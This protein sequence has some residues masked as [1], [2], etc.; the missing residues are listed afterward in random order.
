VCRLGCALIYLPLHVQDCISRLVGQIVA[1][2][3]PTAHLSSDTA[4]AS[5]SRWVLRYPRGPRER[6]V[7]GGAGRGVR[8]ACGGGESRACRGRR[9]NRQTWQVGN[10]RNRKGS[11]D[12]RGG[13]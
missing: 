1:A 10:K 13:D 7:Q 3:D 5:S 11:Q 8:V 2:S 6:R 9:T 4:P 12:V